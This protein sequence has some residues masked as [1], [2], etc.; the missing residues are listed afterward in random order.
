VSARINFN[1][2]V[3]HY[4]LRARPRKRILRDPTFT[5]SVCN[6]VSYTNLLDISDRNLF[7]LNVYVYQL[8]LYQKTYP[9]LE[10]H[11]NPPF[12]I[13]LFSYVK[14][15]KTA[16]LQPKIIISKFC[17]EYS[18]YKHICQANIQLFQKVSATL[19]ISNGICQIKEFIVK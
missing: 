13:N 4:E 2:F 7:F 9:F 11:R 17:K 14:V 6:D 19:R 1:P 12:L 15:Q 5:L 3:T 16:P 10:I 18:I 8:T